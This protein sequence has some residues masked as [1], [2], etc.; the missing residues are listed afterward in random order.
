MLKIYIICQTFHFILEK[1][2]KCGSA[3]RAVTPTSEVC[4]SNLAISKFYMLTICLVSTA[5]N[6]QNVRK[7]CREWHP[8]KVCN[9]HEHSHLY[10]S[11]C[12]LNINKLIKAIDVIF[13]MSNGRVA[14]NFER[15]FTMKICFN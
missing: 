6:R 14:Q 4:G 13:Q 1:V 11:R 15:S 3:G 7:R 5:F 12:Q 9:F 10:L 8:Q 2:S